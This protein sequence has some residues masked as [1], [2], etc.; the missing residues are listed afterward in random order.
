MSNEK[1]VDAYK[2]VIA[3]ITQDIGWR[4]DAKNEILD[5]LN[6]RIWELTEVLGDNN[7]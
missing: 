5:V 1:L 4:K 7:E 3:D 6:H 2:Q